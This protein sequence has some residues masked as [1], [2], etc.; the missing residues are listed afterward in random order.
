MTTPKQSFKLID[1]YARQYHLCFL[2][3]MFLNKG[4]TE[5][6]LCFRP[7]E[8]SQTSDRYACRYLNV[9]V[10]E[11]RILQQAQELT[12]SVRILLNKELATLGPPV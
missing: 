7:T 6:I 9:N 5:Y 8:E 12:D 4:Q 10:G 1:S 2:A 11:I 3:E